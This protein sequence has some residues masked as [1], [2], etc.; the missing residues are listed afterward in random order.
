MPGLTGQ[1]FKGRD[2]VES[3]GRP[4]E[5]PFKDTPCRQQFPNVARVDGPP[6]AEADRLRRWKPVANRLTRRPRRTL[7]GFQPVFT[8]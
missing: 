1:C 8:C 6:V 7:T 4:L 3:L 2:R 5:L